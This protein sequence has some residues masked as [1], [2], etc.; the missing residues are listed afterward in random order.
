MAKAR[1]AAAA[2]SAAI[3]RQIEE[4]QAAQKAKAFPHDRAEQ[5]TGESRAASEA[6]EKAAREARAAAE[7]AAS[8]AKETE[9]QPPLSEQVRM[10][11]AS[12]GLGQRN[13]QELFAA[14]GLAWDE[15]GARRLVD[16]AARQITAS[17]QA[18]GESSY[19][20][21]LPN[22]EVNAS[23]V[24]SVRKYFEKLVAKKASSKKQ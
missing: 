15:A 16:A 4:A 19:S 3:T 2:A 14:H 11:L 6:K 20:L 22:G 13:L 9:A 23:R 17:V 12:Y 7:A 8:A 18:R 10:S 5:M 24:T 1:A 21:T